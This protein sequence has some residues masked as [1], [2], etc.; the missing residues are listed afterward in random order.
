MRG[1][2][3]GGEYTAIRGRRTLGTQSHELVQRV[4][5]HYGLCASCEGLAVFVSGPTNPCHTNGP[6]SHPAMP[7]P[8]LRRTVS[9]A[10]MDYVD[11]PLLRPSTVAA[12]NTAPPCNKFTSAYGFLLL[13]FVLGSWLVGAGIFSFSFLL[14][15]Q[16]NHLYM[17]TALILGY[18]GYRYV[19]LAV[20][21]P[22][23]R[24]FFAQGWTTSPYFRTQRTVIEAP[25]KDNS[26]TLIA[27]HPHGILCCEMIT[28][29]VCAPK[30]AKHIVRFLVSDM[31]FKLPLVADLL[32]WA[33]CS[34][35]DKQTMLSAMEDGENLSIL[36]GGYQEATLCC[37]NEHRVFI[38]Q[39]KGFI[40]Y[41]LMHE[42]NVHPSYIFGE[43]KT[44]LAASWPQEKLM[45]LNKWKL[46]P[47]VFM[48]KWLVFM[49]ENQLGHGD[50]GGAAAGLAVD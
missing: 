21:W 14:A 25:I 34:P 9:I 31:L 27:A 26:K 3:V 33:K 37:R 42:Y 2:L 49:P 13:L 32:T 23:M 1:D 40:K 22:G 12:S 41:D 35:A 11:D 36:P 44:Y 45:F 10:E 48:G 28:T 17:V 38:K 6:E 50:C 4:N 5:Y 18:Y 43:E 39:R 29:L 46:P 16:L 20:E 15:Y 30:L 24:E 8:T 47:V 19:F 7:T